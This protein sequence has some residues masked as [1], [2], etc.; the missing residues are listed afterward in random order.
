MRRLIALALSGG[1]LSLSLT[2]C[3]KQADFL[4]SILGPEGTVVE[5]TRTLNGHD[6]TKEEVL[7]RDNARQ[8]SAGYDETIAIKQTWEKGASLKGKAVMMFDGS[9]DPENIQLVLLSC[10]VYDEAGNLV[11]KN[12]GTVEVTCSHKYE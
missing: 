2:A 11:A 10:K 9:K 12:A 8:Q 7:Q 5:I 6:S 3:A 1:L 4:F